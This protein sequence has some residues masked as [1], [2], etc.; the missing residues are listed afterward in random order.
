SPEGARSAR[1]EGTP[2]AQGGGEGTATA[3]QD[4][5]AVLRFICL[6]L[7]PNLRRTREE[8][9]HLLHAL[10][11]GYVPAGPSGAPSRGM[12]HVLPTGRNFYAIDPRSIP[13]ASAWQIVES[14]ARELLE[15]HLRET[16]RYPESV[17]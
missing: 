9:E 4:I 1:G 6:E 10:D 16:V 3:L 11:G 8:I 14:L 7:V 17:G 5:A 15:R 2:S 13:S 12:A